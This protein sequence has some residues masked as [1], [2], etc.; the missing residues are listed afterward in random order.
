M[1]SVSIE[2]A[3]LRLLLTH[4]VTPPLTVDKNIAEIDYA[5]VVRAKAT[6]ALV[7]IRI[8]T[9][10]PTQE[11]VKSYLPGKMNVDYLL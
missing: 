3:T 1:S 5:V 10:N 2:L 4:W 11:N 9:F 7:M 8:Y 6:N